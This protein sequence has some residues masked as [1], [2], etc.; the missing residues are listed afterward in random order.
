MRLWNCEFC[1]KW[2]FEKCEFCEKWDFEIVNF[3][4]N[5]TLQN[6]NFWINWGILPRAWFGS[7]DVFHFQIG[8]YN[9]TT[10]TPK[11]QDQNENGICDDEE[12]DYDESDEQKAEDEEDDY[13]ES[14]EQKAQEEDYDESEETK[15]DEEDYEE[16]DEQM[17][18]RES[19][20]NATTTTVKYPDKPESK[21]Y[22]LTY[23]LYEEYQPIKRE[24]PI[25]VQTVP[26]F[27]L[28]NF[29]GFPSNTF[30]GQKASFYSSPSFPNPLVLYVLQQAPIYHQA[31]DSYLTHHDLPRLYYEDLTRTN[32][33]GSKVPLTTHIVNDAKHH[34]YQRYHPAVSHKVYITKFFLVY[35]IPVRL[36]WWKY[37]TVFSL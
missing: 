30:G 25:I 35:Y 1:E 37:H 17:A 15:A 10:T 29:Y 4:K 8:Y 22:E 7:G 27:S 13:D 26:H 34:E 5:E 6:V 12:E 11:C 9:T 16:S 18:E 28:N 33:Y 14:D 36:H 21:G 2:D 32:H 20:P 31:P 23:H 19:V 24:V 3:V